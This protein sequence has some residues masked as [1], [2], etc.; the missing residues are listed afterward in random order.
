MA[1]DTETQAISQR[2]LAERTGISVGLVNAI[3]KRLIRTGC[4]KVIGLNRR[5]VRYLLTPKGIAEKTSRSYHFILKT[6]A[7]YQSIQQKMICLVLEAK[8]KGFQHICLDGNAELHLLMKDIVHHKFP[9]MKIVEECEGKMPVAI[10]NLDEKRG[11]S[12]DRV[13]Y[14]SDHI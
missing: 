14:L 8:Q 4:V 2:L 7:H 13:F 6:V 10:V 11:V 9:D 1:L 3:L 12:S 5:A